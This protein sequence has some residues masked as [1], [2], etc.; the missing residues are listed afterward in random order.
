MARQDLWLTDEPGGN[1]LVLVATSVPADRDFF[2]DVLEAEGYEVALAVDGQDAF[3]EVVLN[4]PV[5]IVLDLDL[6]LLSGR[7]VLQIRSK[8][9][10][11]ATIPVLVISD[12]SPHPE[13]EGVA[14][15]PFVPEK[16]LA[17]VRRLTRFL[18][19]TA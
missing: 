13:V 9:E 6:P 15:R 11:L 12:G 5:L 10:R 18:K 8:Y 4:R 14:T 7:G 19:R 17:E 2:S 1:P 16:V 3:R